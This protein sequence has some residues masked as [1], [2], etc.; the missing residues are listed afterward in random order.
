M[1]NEAHFKYVCGFNFTVNV[2]IFSSNSPQRSVSRRQSNNHISWRWGEGGGGGLIATCLMPKYQSHAQTHACLAHF[3]VAEW[4][5]LALCECACLFW[6]AQLLIFFFS[7]HT[8]RNVKMSFFCGLQA[9]Q[10]GDAGLVDA[11]TKLSK[12]FY[13]QDFLP[14]FTLEFWSTM[15]S[16]LHCPAV[17]N[18]SSVSLTTNWQTRARVASAQTF[19]ACMRL[20]GK[21]AWKGQ[22]ECFF[23]PF[24]W[25]WSRT[26]QEP[27][28]QISNPSVFHRHVSTVFTR[29]SQE[30]QGK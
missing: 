10:D 25:L 21:T 28:G 23:F 6:E 13:R 19:L 5:N 9:V 7:F 16:F 1:K 24:P 12:L 14:L 15:C 18:S 2:I 4:I 17:S 3:P 22:G 11:F 29:L 20:S 27:R 8:V 30:L 26:E